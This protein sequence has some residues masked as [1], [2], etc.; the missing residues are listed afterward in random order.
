MAKAKAKTKRS[1]SA[2][3]PRYVSLSEAAY[4]RLEEMIVMLELPP[5]TVVSES[6]LSKRLGIGRTPIG[7]AV[8]RLAQQDLITI[9][10]RRGIVIS[11]INIKKQLKLLEVRR[12][13]ERLVA[14][15]AARRAGPEERKRFTEIAE[16]M[17]ATVRDE[18]ALGFV[19]LDHEFNVLCATAAR[20]EYAANVMAMMQSLSRRFWVLHYKRVADLPRG[21]KAHADVA[22]A[23]AAGDE[24]AAAKASD[25]LID[26]IEE[27]T[28]ASLTDFL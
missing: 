22:R 12:E 9:M 24:K 8:S 14:R 3:A 13:V 20:N 6:E 28:R 19:R 23:I 25:R 10:P 7:E 18:D 16:A 17:D 5:G 27:F 2:A 11:E 21:V 15:C 1:A 4:R 26:Y